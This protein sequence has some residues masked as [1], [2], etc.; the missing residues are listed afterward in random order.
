MAEE[1][2]SETFSRTGSLDDTWDIGHHKRLA[3]AI[4]YDTEVRL[5]G[6]KRIIGN[7]GLGRRYG[8]QQG[9]LSGIGESNKAYIGQ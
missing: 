8:S 3:V 6:C 9:G 4:G 5:Q 2:E 7:L 1:A